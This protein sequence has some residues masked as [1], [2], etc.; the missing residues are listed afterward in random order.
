M[1]KQAKHR[2][3]NS[4]FLTSLIYFVAS[5]FLFYVFADTLILEEKKEAEIKTISLQHVA[6]VEQTKKVE[7]EPIIEPEIIPEPIIETKQPIKKMEKPKEHV[8]REKKPEHKP[9]HK[10]MDKI[11]EQKNETF[12]T[13]IQE[14]KVVEKVEIVPPSKPMLSENEKQNIESEY[15]SKIRY[16]IEE[17]KNYPKIAKRLNHTGKVHVTFIISKNGKI[18]DYKIHKSAQFD[19]LDN[20]ALDIFKTIASFEPIPEKLNKD[21]WE[22]TIPIVYQITRS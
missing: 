5:F 20:A 6:L 14:T 22:I 21:T 1:S 17:N 16:K 13:L 11:V 4:F 10:K 15:L 7:P 3:V 19:S 8:K 9:I 2:Y 18:K 12:N